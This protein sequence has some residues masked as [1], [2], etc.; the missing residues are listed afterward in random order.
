MQPVMTLIKSLQFVWFSGHVM[1][2]LCSAIYLLCTICAH[3]SNLLYRLT[4]LSALVSYGIV[5]F[6]SYGIPRPSWLY[7]QQLATDENM[8]YFGLALFWLLSN[9]ISIVLIPYATYSWFHTLS[10]I[11]TTWIHDKKLQQQIKTWTNTNYS[12]GMRFVAIIEVAFITGMLLL[13]VL[14]LHFLPLIV[15]GHFLRFRYLSSSYTRTA[16]H[17]L[18]LIIAPQVPDTLKPTY[19]A[20]RNMLIRYAH[21]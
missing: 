12:T 11:R 13:G 19:S 16:F 20:F 6:K 7:V 18:D 8:H 15:H 9:R 10:Y 2:L 14:R 17:D 1:T 4:L 3:P 5:V 21:Q